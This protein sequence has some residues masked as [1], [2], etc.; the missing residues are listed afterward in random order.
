MIH[1]NYGVKTELHGPWIARKMN[2]WVLQ[3]IRSETLQEVKMTTLKLSYFRHI[4]RWSGSL[5]KI[6]ILGQIEGRRKRGITNERWIDSINETI[7]MSLQE[8]SRAVEERM[9]WISL[10]HRVTRSQVTRGHVTTKPSPSV[11]FKGEHSSPYP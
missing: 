2:K 10:I 7:S 3:Q 9:L 5:K 1:F 4:K 8:L 11:R 6:I